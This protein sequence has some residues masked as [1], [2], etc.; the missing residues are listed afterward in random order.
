M[1]LLEAKPRLQASSSALSHCE[2]LHDDPRTFRRQRQ[3]KQRRGV[4]A[5]EM[6]IA[7]PLLIMLI[8]GMIEIGRALMVQ[9][10]LTNASR[11]GARVAVTGGATAETVTAAVEAYANSIINAEVSVAITPAYPSLA[12]SGTPITVEVSVDYVDV[13]W[14]PT[15]GYLQ[16]AE[17]KAS[18]VMRRETYQ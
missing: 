5:V 3:C 6:A 9:Q 12:A 17:L 16:D 1:T 4:A 7:M 11:E 8:F 15:P 10:V 13:G 18:S 2:L 14:L